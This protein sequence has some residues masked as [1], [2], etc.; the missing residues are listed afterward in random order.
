MGRYSAH[1]LRSITLF[2]LGGAL[3][4]AA[5]GREPAGDIFGQLGEIVEIV[6]G[7]HSFLSGIAIISETIGFATVLLFLGVIVFSAGFTA[8][9]VPKGIPSFIVS[10]VT[11]NILWV[12]WN[13]ALKASPGECV[14]AMIRSNIIIIA[15]AAITAVAAR[16][17]AR[18]RRSLGGLLRPRALLDGEQAASLIREYQERSSRLSS[19]LAEDILFS[20]NGDAVRLSG[21]TLDQ[22]GEL[23]ETIEKIR[24]RGSKQPL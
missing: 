10:L 1:I 16:G 14:A 20:R 7:V 15:P 24:E 12:L 6:R 18:L 19:A 4:L 21:R 22:A 9:G 3:P 8:V 11:A 2:L 23:G 13:I 17:S 5:E